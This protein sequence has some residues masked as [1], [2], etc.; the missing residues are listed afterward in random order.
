MLQMGGGGLF[1]NEYLLY[2]IFGDC[3][4]LLDKALVN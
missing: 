4:L 2:G 1:L 3:E